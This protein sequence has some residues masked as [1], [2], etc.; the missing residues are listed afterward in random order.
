MSTC[1]P[2]SPGRNPPPRLF[3]SSPSRRAANAFRRPS[4]VSQYQGKLFMRRANDFAC[5]SEFPGHLT[6][7]GLL[8]RYLTSP[9]PR[10]HR[11]GRVRL[12][13]A[14]TSALASRV[15]MLT[16]LSHDALTMDR[17][18]CSSPAHATLACQATESSGRS[19]A[20]QLE[21][22]AADERRD[23][24]VTCLEA[25]YATAHVTEMSAPSRTDASVPCL[26]SRLHAYKSASSPPTQSCLLLPS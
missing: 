18:V 10:I 12:R 5:P 16:L 6:L 24:L 2:H 3:G 8:C 13:A 21:F 19:V 4:G 20:C 9:A 23:T 14:A 22:W 7:A 15:T 26:E 1:S 11:M 17:P 25:V